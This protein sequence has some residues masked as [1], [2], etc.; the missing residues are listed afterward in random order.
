MIEYRGYVGLKWLGPWRDSR[1][2]A[3]ADVDAHLATA[4][5]PPK[6]GRATG[7]EERVDDSDV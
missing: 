6:L 1:G 5:P 4:G 2:D 7:I 3:Q